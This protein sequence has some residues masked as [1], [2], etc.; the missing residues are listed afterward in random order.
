M[1]KW[2]YYMA[3]M[4]DSAFTFN[5]LLP[6]VSYECQI[7]SYCK[8]DFS[9]SSDYSAMMTYTTLS[10]C[11]VP[12]TLLTENILSNSAVL[13]WS[14]AEAVSYRVRIKE[15]T[16]NTWQA[17]RVRNAKTELIINNL[18]ASTTYVW[19]IRSN[20][21]NGSENDHSNY[22]TFQ[23]FTTLHQPPR[24]AGDNVT[25][26]NPS[27]GIQLYPNPSNGKFLIN[28]AKLTSEKIEIT[29][30]DVFGKVFIDNIYPAEEEFKEAFDISGL[31][32]GVYFVRIHKGSDIINRKITKQ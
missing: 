27:D 19:Q 9:D 16:S 12:A 3:Q 13:R 15:D 2:K 5:N 4:Q 30:T 20:C 22:S 7:M 10:N 32:A 21:S 14:G 1:K 26:P 18:K 25:E 28:A 29:V 23:T 6:G 24:I 17:Y 11:F 31:P 8:S